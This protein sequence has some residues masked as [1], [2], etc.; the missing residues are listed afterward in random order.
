MVRTFT[1]MCDWELQETFSAVPGTSEPRCSQSSHRTS[2]SPSSPAI[3]MSTCE[4]T[5]SPSEA[6]HLLSLGQHSFLIFLCFK[7]HYHPQSLCFGN[8]HSLVPRA[9]SLVSAHPGI[10]WLSGHLYADGTPKCFCLHTS[11][12]HLQLWEMHESLSECVLLTW[13]G[14]YQKHQCLR[15]SGEAKPSPGKAWRGGKAFLWSK[16]NC[17]WTI[18]QYVSKLLATSSSS[19]MTPEPTPLQGCLLEI[20]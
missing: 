16:E 5:P 15:P 8:D 18:D 13:V 17:W 12:S 19:G 10:L 4:Y 11:D 2:M 9:F 6:I 14:P 7:N 20:G 3:R 1:P